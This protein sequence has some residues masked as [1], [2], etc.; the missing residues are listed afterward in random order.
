MSIAN[1][2]PAR[3]SCSIT[4][5]HQH[6]IA[7]HEIEGYARMRNTRIWGVAAAVADGIGDCGMG[8]RSAAE[9]MGLEFHR[10]DLGTI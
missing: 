5:S 1:A 8:L 2:A 7:A 6:G 3:A 4:C 10:P 9:A